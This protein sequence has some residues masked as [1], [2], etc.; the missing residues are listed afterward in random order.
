MKKLRDVKEKN[1]KSCRSWKQQQQKNHHSIYY[2]VTISQSP[3]LSLSRFPSFQKFTSLK[4]F[5]FLLITSMDFCVY[6][7]LPKVSNCYFSHISSFIFAV[8]GL[9]RSSPYYYFIFLAKNSIRL[10]DADGDFSPN[11]H[12]TASV[13]FRMNLLVLQV[14]ISA[15]V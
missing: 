15:E 9:P 8:G 12:V 3:S 14:I 10:E 6:N 13:C 5:Q 7:L 11:M 2:R 1:A 4:F